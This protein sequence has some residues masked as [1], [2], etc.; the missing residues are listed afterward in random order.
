MPQTKQDSAIAALN[1]C[2]AWGVQVRSLRSQFADFVKQYNSE[3]YAVTWAALATAGQNTDGSLGAADGA[4][5]TGHPIDTRVVTTVNRAVSET[6]AVAMVTFMSDF[7]NFLGN[8][9]V[10]T[11]QRSQTIDDLAG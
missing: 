4:P 11:S 7:A 8:G 3:G 5:N 10:T 1:Q 6:A 9:A 2:I